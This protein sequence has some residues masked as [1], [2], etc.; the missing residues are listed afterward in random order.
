[1][2][3]PARVR[4]AVSVLDPGPG[5]RVLEFGSGPGV[6]AMLV[7]ERLT[8]GRL[9]ALDRS[10]VATGRTVRRCAGHVAAGRLEVRTGEL[11]ALDV[12]DGSFDAAFGIDVNLFWTRSPGSETALL[13]RVLRPGG[14]LH[15]CYGEVPGGAD[16]VT[17][18]VSAALDAAGFEGIAVRRG[19]DGVAISARTPP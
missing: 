11:D 2:K 14:A 10:A 16:K 1:V 5:D 3:I 19:P 9:L 13:R 17:G 7:C 12:P 8:T 15:V 4:W 6:A 18:P